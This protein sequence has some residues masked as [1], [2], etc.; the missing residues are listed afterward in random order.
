[1]KAD[2]CSLS[3]EIQVLKQMFK[4]AKLRGMELCTRIYKHSSFF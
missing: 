4:D 1:M 2:V 3:N